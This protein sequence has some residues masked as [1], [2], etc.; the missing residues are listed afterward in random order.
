MASHALPSSERV[1]PVTTKTV[2]GGLEAPRTSE[3][4]V[5]P[6]VMEEIT[7]SKIVEPVEHVR[8]ETRVV[9]REL[10]LETEVAHEEIEV[11]RVPVGRFVDEA[12]TV[13]V[14]G[15]TTIV[16]VVEEVAFVTKRLLLKEEVH[17]TKRRVVEPR[18]ATVSVREEHVH[19]ERL[20]ADP[21]A[22]RKQ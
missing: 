19:V 1:A 11:S 7:I 21:A 20:P 8:A 22:R 4:Q 16:P 13:R 14:D 6:V 3:E 5:L 15:D 9:E 18:T 2:P 12:P 17:L 10:P